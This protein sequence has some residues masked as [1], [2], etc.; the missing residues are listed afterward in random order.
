MINQF[1]MDEIKISLY[2]K[3]LFDLCYDKSYLAKMGI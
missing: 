2:I 3:D 1:Q